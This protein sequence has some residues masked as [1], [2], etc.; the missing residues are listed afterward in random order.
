MCCTREHA[1]SHKLIRSILLLLLLA[2]AAN[3]QTRRDS[4]SLQ[5]RAQALEPLITSAAMRHGIDARVLRA[6]CFIESRF[7][8]DAVS[9][10]G[11][12]GPMQFIPETASRYGLTNPHDPKAAMDAAAR[13]LRDLLKKFNGRVDL[14]VA[15]YNAGEGA[16]DSFRT[17]KPLVL[18][19]G[20]VINSR[21]L[22]TGG[23][24]PYRETQTYVNQIM[25]LLARPYPRSAQASTLLTAEKTSPRIKTRD[26][27]LDVLSSNERTAIQRA[28]Q[29]NSSF[30]EIDGPH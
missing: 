29:M 11:A 24:P 15:A 26:F 23:I 6:V 21:G 10:K 1:M 17:G 5:E 8:V 19:T 30:I 16:V 27:T 9:P 2:V 3:G 12:R 22:V 4:P 20:K 28:Q 18:R 14:A 13:Y 7:R 25:G